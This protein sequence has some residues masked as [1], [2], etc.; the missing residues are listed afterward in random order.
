MCLR[1]RP[2][3]LSPFSNGQPCPGST[4]PL[5]KCP[6]DGPHDG[7]ATPQDASQALR[8]IAFH[9]QA[10]FQSGGWDPATS[11][12]PRGGGVLDGLPTTPPPR[13][14]C[15]GPPP[16]TRLVSFPQHRPLPPS[17]DQLSSIQEAQ[18]SPGTSGSLAGYHV[19][20]PGEQR[21]GFGT[22]EGSSWSPSRRRTS[23]NWVH[24]LHAL[25][26]TTPATLPRNWGQFCTDSPPGN[27]CLW[28]GNAG[29]RSQQLPAHLESRSQVWSEDRAGPQLLRIR[30]RGSLPPRPVSGPPLAAHRELVCPEQALT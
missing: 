7:G 19:G 20:M 26:T 28:K 6:S 9:H 29:F 30:I 21:P 25:T 13:G 5:Q 14:L 4:Q 2:P 15:E 22:H 24:H 27:L 23:Q 3:H 11:A 10:A 16:V 1:P 18:R 12:A 17:H 8:S